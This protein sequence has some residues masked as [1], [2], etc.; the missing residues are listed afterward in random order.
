MELSAGAGIPAL[1]RLKRAEENVWTSTRGTLSADQLLTLRGLIDAWISENSDRSV[2]ALVRFNEF[3]DKR[4]NSSLSLCGKARGLCCKRS[5]KPAR[6]LTTRV[7]WENGC[8][9]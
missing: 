6:P 9:G 7:C 1:N 5:A 3:A 2:V 4:K 8:F